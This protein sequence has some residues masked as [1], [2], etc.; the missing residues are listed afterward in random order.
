LKLRKVLKSP[1]T[2]RWAKSQNKEP[3]HNV[4]RGR[5]GK[6]AVEKPLSWSASTVHKKN[7]GEEKLH[8]T[9]S[10]G[11]VSKWGNPPPATRGQTDK[12]APRQK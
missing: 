1:E 12:G 7:A 2:S 11:A 8:S 10:K 3:A 9:Q 5:A 4:V 6:E